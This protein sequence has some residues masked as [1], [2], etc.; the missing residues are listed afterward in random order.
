MT[1]RRSIGIVLALLVPSCAM[2]EYPE[3][4]SGRPVGHASDGGGG[5]AGRS[6]S[7]GPV[8]RPDAHTVAD[9]GTVVPGTDASAPDTA[10]SG[11]L[12]ITPVAGNGQVVIAAWPG[13]EPM[14]VQV[15][16]DRGAPVAGVAVS[17]GMMPVL[18]N[19]HPQ[20]TV[21]DSNGMVG[22]T[23]N[24]SPWAS[25]ESN[26]PSTVTAS[27]ASG[28]SATFAITATNPGP[29]GSIPTSA[30][31]EIRNP[32]PPIALGSGRAG[33]VIPGAIQAIVVN[34]Q[35]AET[36]RPIPNV[37]LEIL[38]PND[39]T[40]PA[41]AHCLHSVGGAVLTDATG[42]VTC[43]LQ[44]GTTVGTTAVT[45]RIGASTMWT[46]SLTITP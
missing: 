39:P 10:T 28:E 29:F 14:I 45:V 36:G 26:A 17:W 46:M 35:G 8:A 19:L 25:G 22:C 32:D 5:D 6:D 40:Q 15:T 4:D 37:G 9:T 33:S 24:A 7:G 18:G 27:L 2:G 31:I 12:H 11:G 44:L 13:V 38:N 1:M 20:D 43:D 42:I 21:T 30:H 16:D 34:S 23:W 3:T 41:A